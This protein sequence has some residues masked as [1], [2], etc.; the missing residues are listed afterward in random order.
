MRTVG[1][2]HSGVAS[3]KVTPSASHC[4]SS[5]S[6]DP[7][8]RLARA[9]V[10]G[11]ALFQR[12]R[13]LAASAPQRS[14]A[15][16]GRRILVRH[17]EQGLRQ[18]CALSHREPPWHH[19]GCVRRMG[20]LA[21]TREPSRNPGRQRPLFPTHLHTERLLCRGATRREPARSPCPTRKSESESEV[22]KRY[23]VRGNQHAS[24]RQPSQTALSPIP[25]ISRR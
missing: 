24:P 5:S 7:R 14:C 23:P 15:R 11:G 4:N 16:L 20:N 12:S 3:A 17:A 9:K 6:S 13:S 2:A 21:S 18:A 8:S 22:T 1:G 19:S 25:P 10:C